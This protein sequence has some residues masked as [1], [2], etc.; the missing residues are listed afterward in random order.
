MKN[1][2]E[3]KHTPVDEGKAIAKQVAQKPLDIPSFKPELEGRWQAIFTKQYKPD[4]DIEWLVSEVLKIIPTLTDITT[5]RAIY[6]SLRGKFPDRKFRGNILGSDKFYDQLTGDGMEKVQLATMLTM[7]SLGVWAAPR[8][9]IAGDGRVF[10]SRRGNIPL[11]A[12]PTLQFDLADNAR[13]DSN[14]HKVIHFEKDAGFAN[15]V[16][17]DMS[18]YIETVWSTSQG[19][20]SESANKFLRQAEDWGLQIYC[21]HDSDVFGL[22]MQLLYGIASK[23]NCFMPSEF[24]A[25]NVKSLGFFPSIANLLK[26]P[27][28]KIT[29][30]NEIRLF[31]NLDQMAE[32]HPELKPEIAILQKRKEKWEF[33][34]L[35]A[36]HEKAPQIYLVEG[37]RA[38]NDEIKHVPEKDTVKQAVIHEVNSGLNMLVSDAIDSATNKALEDIRQEV[39]QNIRSALANKITEFEA[40]MADTIKQ[41]ESTPANNFREGI[42][43]ELVEDPAIYWNQ[44]VRRLAAKTV[45]AHFNAEA[46]VI[47]AVEVNNV[48]ADS[49]I[50]LDTPATR[51]ELTKNDIVASIESKILRRQADRDKVVKPIR[52]AFEKVFGKPSQEW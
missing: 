49:N 4:A 11:T 23:S 31:H 9:Y 13:L 40:E 51:Q 33:Q 32:E 46:N 42:K 29:S 47:A 43:A 16:A 17:G 22:M 50:T 39:E 7:Q 21:V 38:K 28:E 37:L 6:Y 10:S 44:A 25:Q 20:L 2:I 41:L 19:Q 18:K 14:A 30:E 5:Q 24:Y 12:Q 8:G 35:N 45:K 26:L 36:I 15:L 1:V 34:A 52:G 27:P 3:I 48:N